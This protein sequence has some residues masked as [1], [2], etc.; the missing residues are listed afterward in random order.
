M[1]EAN[2]HSPVAMEFAGKNVWVTGAAQ[3]IGYQVAMSFHRQGARVFGLDIDFSEGHGEGREYPFTVQ[4]VD[5]ACA[6]SVARASRELLAQESQ[7]DVLVN[8]AGVLRLG[9]TEQLTL[10]DWYTCLNVNASGAFYLLRQVIPQF[11]QQRHGSVVT[12][13]SNAAHVPRLQMAA[14]CASKAALTSL[15]HCVALE[16]A[17]FNVRCNV[18]SPGSTD[19]RMQRELWRSDDAEQQTIAGFQQQF[20]L[21]IPLGK[22]ARPEEIAQVV[23]FLASEQASHVTMQD[24]VVDGGAVLTA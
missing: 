17:P 24:I 19:T 2:T 4:H 7:I 3:G 12:V 1:K 18:V 5:L 11:K 14:Y 9:D 20:K 15:S 22:I 23:M 21:G 6:D 10:D 16:L 13:S 8:V